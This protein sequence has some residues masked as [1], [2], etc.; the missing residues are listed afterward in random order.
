[1]G[2]GRV[3]EL[4]NKEGWDCE[5]GK[6]HEGAHKF[7]EDD[8]PLTLKPQQ[9][10]G[11]FGKGRIKKWRN[12]GGKLLHPNGQ[13]K[14]RQNRKFWLG[15]WNEKNNKSAQI[16]SSQITQ[17][18]ADNWPR[19]QQEEIGYLE[20]GEG[21]GGGRRML[22]KC[23]GNCHGGRKKVEKSNQKKIFGLKK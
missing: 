5:G 17:E 15:V 23:V 9:K 13:P 20:R 18:G 22:E 6:M 4:K 8:C 12:Y 16:G 3:E 1:M 11:G 19:S 2:N 14:N 10:A 21:G 7:A